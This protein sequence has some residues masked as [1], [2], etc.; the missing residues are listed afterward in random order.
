MT[1]SEHLIENPS[2]PQETEN[3][4]DELSASFDNK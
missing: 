4:N 2:E 1:E 3:P